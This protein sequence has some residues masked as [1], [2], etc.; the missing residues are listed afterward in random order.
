MPRTRFVLLLCVCCGCPYILATSAFAQSTTGQPTTQDANSAPAAS[1]Q[2]SGEALRKAAQNP[3]ASMISVPFQNNTNF[4]VEPDDRIQDVLNIQPVVPAGVSKDWNLIT[5]WITPII[6]QPLP[7][8]GPAPEVG[9]Y[10]FGDMQPNFFL[11]PK[12]AGKLIWGG[13]PAFQLPTGTDTYLGQG[14]LGLGPTLVVLSQPGPW[15]VGATVNNIWSVAGSGSRPDV[16][17][18]A[19][20]YFINYNLKKGWYIGSSPSLAA[21]WEK[22]DGGRW[23]LPFGGVI[24]RVTRFGMQPVHLQ[25]GFYGNAVH[26]ENAPS[27]SMRV[28]VVLLFPRSR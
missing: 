8:Q 4:G 9:K 2:A 23:V 21:D 17:Q 24:G 6:W 16:N 28:M 20:Q 22:L 19:L 27:W 15:T 10:G 1:G 26:P 13:G 12:K 25:L 5:R 18:M 7:P 3:I 11:S 14:K